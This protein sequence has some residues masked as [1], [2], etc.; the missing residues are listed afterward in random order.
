[1]T[2]AKNRVRMVTHRGIEKEHI[3]KAIVAIEN[4]S[5]ELRIACT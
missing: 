5:N 1:L 3:E 2:N 4:V